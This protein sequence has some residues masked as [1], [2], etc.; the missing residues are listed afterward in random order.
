MQSDATG[1]SADDLQRAF[2]HLDDEQRAGVIRALDAVF[3][4]E[5]TWRTDAIRFRRAAAVLRAGAA[6]MAAIVLAKGM[7]RPS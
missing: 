2:P 7:G 5:G 1:L 3:Q 6:L 4:V